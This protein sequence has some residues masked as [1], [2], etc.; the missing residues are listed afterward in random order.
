MPYAL[1]QVPAVVLAGGVND[2]PL[3]EG[4][5][6]GY[7]ALLPLGGRP[8][9]SYTLDA[10]QASPHVG[11]IC[12]VGAEA[13]LREALG[14]QAAEYDFAA[15]GNHLLESIYSGLQHFPDA[16]LVLMVTADVP[17]ITPAAVE[18]FL[19]ACA[20]A[21]TTYPENF[22]LSV[23]PERCYT[24]DYAPSTKPFNHFRDISICHGSLML[25]DPRLLQNTGATRRIDALYNARKNPV[26]AAMAVG[27]R[28]GL[29]FVLGVHLWHLLTI[30][31]M[32]AIASRRFGVGLVP[33]PL[34]HPEIT[35]DIDEP[36]D[37]TFVV[38]HL[39]HTPA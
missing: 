38:E 28:V 3:F 34:D 7:K 35:I 18:D 8:S 26:D 29:S 13:P 22:Y 20:R 21:E 14:S 1:Q 31:Q 2:I 37:Y 5:T 33:I 9:V 10:L 6:P 23:V 36:A 15:S 27:M 16:P 30:Q 19:A 39:T 25:I 4:Y 11:R 32:A 24:G 17:L 12:L